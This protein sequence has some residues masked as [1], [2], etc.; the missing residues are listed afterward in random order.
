MAIVSTN[1]PQLTA[2]AAGSAKP[3]SAGAA[4]ATA[5]DPTDEPSAPAAVAQGTTNILGRARAVATSAAGGVAAVVARTTTTSS[6]PSPRADLVAANMP[7]GSG[8]IFKLCA[9][10]K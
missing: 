5:T 10:L 1:N 8:P 2:S 7:P 4:G 9:D 6:L 3:S